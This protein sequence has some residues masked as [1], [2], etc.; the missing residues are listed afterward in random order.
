[1]SRSAFDPTLDAT[2]DCSSRAPAQARREL[3]QLSGE[4]EIAV[5][6]DVQ[7][8]VSELVTNSVR[9]SGSDDAIRLRAWSRPGGLKVEVADGGFGFEAADDEQG[10][11]AEGGRG[12]VI[13]ETLTDRWGMSRDAKARV[14]FE[15]AA[16]P[17][18][19]PRAQA[20]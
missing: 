16:R 3:E 17:A 7:L 6:R 15:L 11:D 2:I 8:V 12:L 18:T 13:L 1:M 9:H 10:D 5:L 19:G 14:W 4:L 20:G